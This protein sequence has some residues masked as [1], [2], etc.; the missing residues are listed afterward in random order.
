M[1]ADLHIHSW[2][3]DG[4]FSPARLLERARALGVT[5]MAITDH[6]SLRGSDELLALQPDIRTLRAAELS[7]ADRYGL[8]LLLYGVTQARVLTRRVEEL[9]EKRKR[10]LEQMLD[11]LE[12]MGM[13]L[14]ADR[15]M[16][17]SHGT[18]GRPHL[19]KAL[20]D[21]GYVSTL[22][23]AYDRLIGENGPAY[24]EGDKLTMAEALKLANEAGWVP[25]LAH[26][27]NLHL[28]DEVLEAMLD[29]WQAQGLRGMEVY[30][31]SARLTGYETLERMARRRGLLVT[32]GSDFH[33]DNDRGHGT[34]GCTARAWHSAVEDIQALW[35]AVE[36]GTG[37]P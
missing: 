14:T 1:K 23:E 5:H 19:A 12:T 17:D 11:R 22:Q 33:R 26:P 28:T 29:V 18:V 9:A 8:H 13:H 6:D 3:S 31:P 10:R 34:I 25:V 30:H 27:R 20:L 32:G 7:M 16:E 15:V 36:Q 35:Q 4:E 2:W 21:A 37:T 24:V